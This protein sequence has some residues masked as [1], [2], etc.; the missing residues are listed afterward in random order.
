MSS[1]R[2][3]E[4]FYSIQGESTFVGLPTAFIR[5]TGCP[6]RCVYCD[7]T[8]AFKGGEVLSIENILEQISVYK[9]RYV[10]VTG[11]E[12]LAQPASAELLSM[13]CDE[14]YKVSIETSGAMDISVVDERVTVV[15]DLKTPASGEVDKNL[16]SNFQH[17]K[18]QDQI[19]FVIIDRNDY[20]YAKDLTLE[21]RLYEKY[22]VLFS[23]SWEQLPMTDLA[24][25]I[26]EDSLPVR[27]QIQMHKVIWP[28]VNKG[29]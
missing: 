12:P 11:G 3:S 10:T 29:R 24:D 13:L 17:L 5:L 21:R 23:P 1:L 20:L 8:F 16:F 9:A 4:I 22:E 27:Y 6:L 19:K 14:G 15:M 2:I 18:V 25:W 7:T 28:G 26:L